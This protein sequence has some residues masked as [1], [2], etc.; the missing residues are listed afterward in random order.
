[1]PRVVVVGAGLSGL[2]VAFRL[3]QA[4]PGVELAVLE[5]QGRPGGTVWT[6]H[7]DGFRVETGPNGFLDGK[8]G[9]VQLCR[10]LGVAGRLLPASE[11]SRKNRFVFLRDRLHRL[12]ASPPGILTT[13]LLSL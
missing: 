11:V 5:G 13:P 4:L 1:M 6:D 2:A 9:A 3:R 12:P 7:R 8:P 10:D